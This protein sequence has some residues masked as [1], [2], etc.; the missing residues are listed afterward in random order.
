MNKAK[1]LEKAKKNK[2]SISE[3]KSW[4][5]NINFEIEKYKISIENYPYIR[6]QK[7]GIPYLNKLKLE[8]KELENILR[9]IK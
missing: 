7:Y 5:N 6:L 2:L 9:S 1:V 4:I 8:K 3:L